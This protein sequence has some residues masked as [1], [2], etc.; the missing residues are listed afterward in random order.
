MKIIR[1]KYSNN[2]EHL[3]IFHFLFMSRNK[4]KGDSPACA[5]RKHTDSH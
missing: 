4:F 5:T 2:I 1:L 3:Q